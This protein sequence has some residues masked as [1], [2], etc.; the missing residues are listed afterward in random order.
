LATRRWAKA[1]ASVVAGT[2]VASAILAFIAPGS[3]SYPAAFFRWL[4]KIPIV[5]VLY[6]FLEWAGTALLGR[7]FWSR[8]P[9][10]AR[11]ILLVA[12]IVVV[13]VALTVVSVLLPVG[14]K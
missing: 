11:I 9:S 5:V 7:A 3:A 6:A 1:V 8:M 12:F 4:T 13:V 14:V 10:V 2:L